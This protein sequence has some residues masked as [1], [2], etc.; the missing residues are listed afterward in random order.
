[1]RAHSWYIELWRLQLI[2]I[3]LLANQVIKILTR[4]HYELYEAQLWFD[5]VLY[6]SDLNLKVPVQTKI[7]ELFQFWL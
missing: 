2:L 6:F 4:A 7:L 3:S 5:V 1:M